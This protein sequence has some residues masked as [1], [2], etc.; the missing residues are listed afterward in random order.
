MV[1]GSI[2]DF[3][4]GFWV[5]LAIS[6]IINLMNITLGELLKKYVS[7]SKLE[8]IAII[9]FCILGIWLIIKGI[10]ITER[11]LIHNYEDERKI[12]L[13]NKRKNNSIQNNEN[14]DNQINE[15]NNYKKIEINDL[16]TEHI[17]QN[18][19]GVFNSWWQY[20]IT[21]FFASIGGKSQI[22]SIIIVTRYNFIPI[23]NGTAIGIFL[24]VFVAMF[25][26]KFISKLL[27]N[28]Q[29]SIISGIF[30]LMYALVFYIDRKLVKNIKDFNE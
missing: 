1:F 16:E 4:Y 27:T 17:E 8:I 23:F 30:F 19:I 14:E 7:I 2:N 24:L 26:G 29:I 25:I 12:L 9:V 15:D 6:E 21:Y 28:K 10:R 22:A 11:R 3:F 5:T 18:E 20:L 13:N